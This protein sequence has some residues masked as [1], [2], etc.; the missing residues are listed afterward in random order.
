MLFGFY[1]RGIGSGHG[2]NRKVVKVIC[3]SFRIS[4]LREA[5]T[6][7]LRLCQGYVLYSIHRRIFCHFLCLV[8]YELRIFGNSAIG[9]PLDSTAR[10]LINNSPS[11]LPHPSPTLHPIPLNNDPQ[12]HHN[13]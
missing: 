5:A 4:D 7:M 8:I 3:D 10:P 1:E 9:G 12:I 6:K 13:G 11:S 2:G